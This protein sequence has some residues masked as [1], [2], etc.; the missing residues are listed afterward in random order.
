M[1]RDRIRR[2]R[3]RAPDPSTIACIGDELRRVVQDSSFSWMGGASAA[4]GGWS[5]LMLGIGIGIGTFVVWFWMKTTGSVG[6][7]RRS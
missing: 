5:G 3:G 4:S 2:L 1:P 6:S 7:R